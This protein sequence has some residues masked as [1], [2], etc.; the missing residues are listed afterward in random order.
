NSWLHNSLRLVKGRSKCVLLINPVDALKR[1][2]VDG[3][4]VAVSSR[5]G[6]IELPVEIS[7]EIMPGVVSIPHGWGHN[8]PNLQLSVAQEHAGVSLNDLTDELAID[9]V[10]GSA[11]FSGVLV[12]VKAVSNKV[13]YSRDLVESLKASD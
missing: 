11:A 2:I 5:V 10:S 3:Q 7:D 1:Q 8:R 4:T 9:A 12:E 6:R 13:S